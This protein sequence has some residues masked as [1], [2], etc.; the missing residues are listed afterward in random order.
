MKKLISSS[1]DGLIQFV[2]FSLVGALNSLVH[3]CVF[4]ALYRIAMLH[5]LASSAIGYGAGMI[6]SY[7]LNRRWTF[8]SSQEKITKEFSKFTLVNTV[9]LLVNVGSLRFFKENASM[10]AEAGQVF[11]IG[12]S[13][14][15][16]F[17]GNRYWTFKKYE[18]SFL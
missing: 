11:A 9:A 1:P 14:G 12:L 2:K 15:V 7:I 10:S 13:L 3:F 6:N 8:S 16:N 17:L 5:Y 18:R 4:M